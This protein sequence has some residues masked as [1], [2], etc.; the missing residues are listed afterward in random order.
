MESGVTVEIKFREFNNPTG[1]D[2]NGKSCE[3]VSSCDT[4]FK[5]CIKLTQHITTSFTNCDYKPSTERY[6]KSNNINFQT[7]DT[8]VDKIIRIGRDRWDG[9]SCLFL[10]LHFVYSSLM[11]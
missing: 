9:V 5:L 8:N 4:F 6:I 11:F 1:R 3:V 7:Q 10:S 2:Y